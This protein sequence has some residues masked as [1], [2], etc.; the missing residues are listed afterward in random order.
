MKTSEPEVK[1]GNVYGIN[2]ILIKTKI[3]GIPY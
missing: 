1:R 3:D 2:E